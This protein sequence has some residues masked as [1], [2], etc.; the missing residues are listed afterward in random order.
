[1][2]EVGGPILAAHGLSDEWLP[3]VWTGGKRQA[4]HDPFRSLKMRHLRHQ[5]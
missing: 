5:S 3:K 4:V 1:M 2:R